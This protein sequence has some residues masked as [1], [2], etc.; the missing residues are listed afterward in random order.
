MSMEPD[1][2]AC[3]IG[4]P[5]VK[6]DHTAWKGSLLIR[7]AAVSSASAPVPFWSPMFRVTLARSTVLFFPEPEEPEA[8]GEDEEQAEIR[9]VTRTIAASGALAAENLF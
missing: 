2:I 4:G 9:A 7:P 1:P 8:P 5:E 3:S 6:S